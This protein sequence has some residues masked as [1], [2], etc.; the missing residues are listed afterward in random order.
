MPLT[1]MAINNSEPF[2]TAPQC[3]SVI[4]AVHGLAAPFLPIFSAKKLGLRSKE[5][6]CIKSIISSAWQHPDNRNYPRLKTP[7]E[8]EKSERNAPAGDI[9]GKKAWSLS[10]A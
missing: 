3:C 7:I 5:N 4:P 2:T 8:A 6:I 9:A 10:Q 1:V